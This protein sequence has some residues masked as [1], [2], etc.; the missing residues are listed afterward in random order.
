MISIEDIRSLFPQLQEKVYGKQL[1]YLDNAATSLRPSAVLD[2]WN[3]MSVQKNSNLH[4]A[5]HHM[6]AIATEEY[7]N[8]REFVRQYI[9]ASS[10]KEIIFTSGATASINLVAYC[11]GEAFVHEGDNILVTES[12]HHSDLVPWQQMCLRKKAELRKIR[13]K[14]NGE[15]D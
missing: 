1:V 11:F 13:V 12:E 8:T 9:N 3:E 7:E 15:L 4:R 2:K 14:D 10:V 5:V 6:A